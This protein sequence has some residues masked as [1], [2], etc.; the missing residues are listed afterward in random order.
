LIQKMKNLKLEVVLAF[1]VV[2]R[3]VMPPCDRRR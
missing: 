1:D 3:A 2:E